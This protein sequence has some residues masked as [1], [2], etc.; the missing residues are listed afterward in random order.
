MNEQ[1]IALLAQAC[2]TSEERDII[3]GWETNLE[4]HDMLY[5][6]YGPVLAKTIQDIK[7]LI[8]DFSPYL[9]PILQEKI[10]FLRRIFSAGERSITAPIG[11]CSGY[12]PRY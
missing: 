3:V 10:L 7:E 11:V 6:L 1:T 8:T 5:H 2:A 12:S 4:Y 9:M